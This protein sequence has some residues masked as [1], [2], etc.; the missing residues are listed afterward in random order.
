MSTNWPYFQELYV[1]RKGNQWCG[2]P[3]KLVS[4]TCCRAQGLGGENQS[5]VDLYGIGAKLCPVKFGDLE[6]HPLVDSGA[7]V[8]VISENNLF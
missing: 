8:S 3:G 5:S 6:M 4:S 7:D 1:Q 2:L